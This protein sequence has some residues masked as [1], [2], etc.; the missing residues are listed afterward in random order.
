MAR[1]KVRPS[2]DP[3]AAGFHE[4][5]KGKKKPRI[6]IKVKPIVTKKGTV[7]KAADVRKLPKFEFQIR[8]GGRTKTTVT[9]PRKK[10]SLKNVSL[11]RI[12]RKIKRK[13]KKKK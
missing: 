12:A 4:L 7:P 13:I 5:R 1:K 11:G 10:R 2:T 8:P 9:V 6:G 3:V